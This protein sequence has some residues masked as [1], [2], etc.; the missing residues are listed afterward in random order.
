MPETSVLWPFP[1]DARRAWVKLRDPA[2][3]RRTDSHCRQRYAMVPQAAWRVGCV[4]MASESARS[5]FRA[6]AAAKAG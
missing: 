1:P 3:I 5:S 2:A 6:Q 4:R